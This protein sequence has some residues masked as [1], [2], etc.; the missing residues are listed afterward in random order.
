MGSSGC[1][2]QTFLITAF[3]LAV[4][5]VITLPFTVT[6]QSAS[7]MIFS[8]EAV[9]NL[10][11]SSLLGSGL[12]ER[13]LL[14][15]VFQGDLALGGGA[16]EGAIAEALQ[17]LSPAER[18]TMIQ[19]I[20]PD[21]WVEDQISTSVESIFRW[22]DDESST[23]RIKLDLVPIKDRL[24]AGGIEDIADTVV[25]SWPSCSPEQINI[26][27]KAAAQGGDFEFDICEPPEPFR[28]RAVEL[29]SITFYEWVRESP[30]SIEFQE[31]SEESFEEIMALKE[32][33]RFLRAIMRFGWFL[34]IALLGLIMALS[35]RSLRNLGSWWGIP[36][37]LGG[38]LTVIAALIVS[39]SWQ[40]VIANNASFLREGG[41][42]IAQVAK[43][44]MNELI[45]SIVGRTFFFGL[46]IMALGA[47]MF[48][49]SR[50][51]KRDGMMKVE[52]Q[53]PDVKAGF[54]S[55]PEHRS[56]AGVPPSVPPISN[57]DSDEPPSGIF[58]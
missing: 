22:I 11:R 44:A 43:F 54:P 35:I 7:Q 55:E 36:I 16:D 6:S 9:T 19:Q 51:I 12:L 15:A 10:V 31:E 3:L 52:S 26:M 50:I 8:P 56:E 33:I 39:G 27:R 42:V 41:E 2:K 38:I 25:D 14:E 46:V 21:G 57:D 58:G 23:P 18:Q 29:A 37:T 49:I 13:Y 17:Y 30:S 48:I 53:S 32:Q 40:G 45:D 4:L 34:P 5:F 28:T 24:I 1:L 47:G 20:V